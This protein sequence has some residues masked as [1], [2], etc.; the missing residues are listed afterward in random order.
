MADQV[1]EGMPGIENIV[2]NQDMPAAQVGQQIRL[3]VKSAGL[4][5][6]PAIT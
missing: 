4:G 1:C 3:D 2:E 5:D 6:R